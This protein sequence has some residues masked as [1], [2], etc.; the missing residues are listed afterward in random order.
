MVRNFL[1]RNF[2]LTLFLIISSTVLSAVNLTISSPTNSSTYDNGNSIAYRVKISNPDAVP[3][4]NLKLEVPLSTLTSTLDSGGSGA[5]FSNLL[6][7]VSPAGTTV[8]AVT[9]T[10]SASGDFL[11]TGITIPVGGSV[12]YT[13]IGTV[14]SGVNGTVNVVSTLKDSSNTILSTQNKSLTRVPYTYTLTKTSPSTYYEQNGTII[15]SVKATNTGS[16]PIYGMNITDTLPSGVTGTNIVGISSGALSDDGTFANTG[17]L[18]ASGVS[19]DAGGYVQYTIIASVNAG[20]TAPINNSATAT[21]RNTPTTSN[22]LNLPLAT[23]NFSIT[24]TNVNSNYIPGSTAS[25]KVRVTNNDSTVKITG[26]TVT[27][28]LSGITALSA[29]GTTKPVFDMTTATISAVTSGVGTNAGTFLATG[30][31]N[32]TGV[33][34]ATSGG[35]VEYTLTAKVQGDIVGPIINPASA[36]DRNGV[37]KS[38]NSTALNSAPPTLT[39]SKNQSPTTTFTPGSSIQYDVIVSNTGSGIAKD[40]NV[41]DLI[42]GITSNLANNGTGTNS[43]DNPTGQPMS[44]WSVSSFLSPAGGKTI[45]ALIS[46]G[47][48]SNNANINDTV[49][50]FPGESIHY[51]ITLNTKSTSIGNISN[52]A[53]LKDSASAPVANSGAKTYTAAALAPTSSATITKITNSTEYKPG[54]TVTYYITVT[55]PDPTKFMDNLAINDLINQIKST[56]LAGNQAQAFANWTV[57]VDSQTGAGTM[58]GDF[59]YGV[60]G[61]TNFQVVADIGPGGSITYKLVAKI[62]DD[63][64]GTILDTAIPG[65]NVIENGTG[66]KMSSPVLEVAK[67]VNTTEYTPGATLVYS[68]TVDNPG[69]GYAINIPVVDNFPSIMTTVLGGG[70]GQAY[71]GWQVVASVYDITNPSSPVLITSPTTTNPGFTGTASGGVNDSFNVTATL[72]PNR[73]IL[74]TMTVVINPLAIGKIVNEAKVNN[75]LVSDKGA[76]TRTS[77][78]TFAKSVDQESYPTLVGNKLTYT[79]VVSNNSVAGLAMGVDVT[80]SINSIQAE[81]LGSGAMANVFTSWTITAVPTGT[82][83]STQLTSP[84]SG[85]NLV[86]KVNIAPGGNITYTI[87]GTLAT[88]SGDIFY[89]PITNSAT[90]QGITDTATTYPKLP[91]LNLVKKTSSP[92]YTPGG[93]VTF[94]IDIENN[95]DGYANNASV[96]DSFPFDKLSGWT[97]TATKT[98]TGTTTGTFTD[99]QNLNT[100]VDIAPRGKVSYTVVA[101]VKPGTTGQI[102]NTASVTDIQNGITQTGSAIIS[103]GG[104]DGDGSVYIKK[105]T[106]SMTF[107]PDGTITYFIDVTNVSGQPVNNLSVKDLFGSNKSTYADNPN[108][109]TSDVADLLNHPTFDSWTI[110]KG[111]N[112]SNP[113]T[114]L[115]PLGTTDLNDTLGTLA[116]G[117]VVTYKV[118]AKVNIR[119]VSPKITNVAELYQNSVKI[120]DSQIEHKIIPPGG[121]ITRTVDKAFYVPGVD[122]ITY[123]ITATSTGP[124]FQN[125]LSLAENINNLSVNLIDGG[126]GNPF[127]NYVTNKNEF[128]VA[129]TI[130]DPSGNVRT[131]YTKGPADNKD[132]VGTLDIPPG[133]TIVYT[134]TGKVRPDAMGLIDNNGLLT[135]QHRYNLNITKKADLIKYEPG[136]PMVYT[137]DIKNNST[138]NAENIDVIDNFKNI[139]VTDS[140]GNQV[141]AFT[142]ITLLSQTV[143]SGYKATTNDTSVYPNPMVNGVLHTLADIPTP[144]EIQYKV[145]VQVTDKA[146]SAIDNIV[147]VGGDSVSNEVGPSTPNL[148]PTKKILN[149]YDLDGTTVLTN[150]YRPGGYVEYEIKVKNIGKGILDNAPFTDDIAGVQ[151]NYFDGTTGKAFDSW[152]IT[153]AGKDTIGTNVTKPDIDGQIQNSTSINTHVDIAAGGYFTYVVKA[154]INEKAVGTFKNSFTVGGITRESENSNMAP[155]NIVFTKKAFEA[156]GTTV[157][158]TFSPGD[159]VVYKVRIDNTGNGTD[160]LK[161]LTDIVSG[162]TATIAEDGLNGTNPTAPVFASYQITATTSGGNVTN[163]GTFT[164]PQTGGDVNQTIS[165]ASKG[166]VELVITGVLKN[167]IIGAFTNRAIYDGTTKA[168]TLNPKAPTLTLSKTLT[169]LAGAPFV[170]GTTK[171]KPGDS[172]K[173]IVDIKNTG[174]TFFDN[175]VITDT[176]NNVVT[177]LTGGSTGPALTNVAVSVQK[178]PSGG[179]TY[180]P[181]PIGTTGVTINQEID[182]APG[183]ELIY[184]ITGNISNDALGTISANSVRA[185]D[186]GNVDVTKT[187]DV[188]L[189]KSPVI[190]TAKTLTSLLPDRIYTPGGTV[191]YRLTMTNSGDGYGN[192]IPMK[193]ILTAVQAEIVGGGTAQAF[194]AWTITPTITYSLPQY[195]GNETNYTGTLA[196]NNDLNIT[197]DIAPG[198]TITVDIVATIRND[199]VGD[200]KNIAVLNGTNKD[201][202]VISSKPG[203]INVT[204]GTTTSSYA[205]DGPL[206]FVVVLTNSSTNGIANN[207]SLTDI[208]SNIQVT[209]AG[210]TLKPAFKP[211]WTISTNIFG[212]NSTTYTAGIPVSGDINTSNIDIGPS[213][214]VV[215]NIN[216]YA[217]SDAVG[218]IVNIGKWTYK[219]KVDQ[220]LTAT[221]IPGPGKLEISKIASSDTYSPGSTITYTMDIKNTGTGYLNNVSILDDILGIQAQIAGAPL[222]TGQAFSSFNVVSV[223]T[224]SSNT[225]VLRDNAYTTGYKAIADIYPGEKVSVKISAVVNANVLGTITNS[226]IADEVGKDP[227]HTD[228]TISPLPPSLNI[229][230]TV[231]KAVYVYQDTLTYNLT[232]TN[233]GVGWA[234]DVNVTD[235]I[236]GIQVSFIDGT[237]GPAFEPSWTISA[238]TTGT[239]TT[240]GVYSN[241]TNINTTVDIAPGGSVTYKIVAQIK[242][243]AN[244]EILNFGNYKLGD[245]LVKSNEVISNPKIAN[246]SITKTTK[247]GQT[248]YAVDGKVNYLITVKNLENTVANNVVVKDLISSIIVRSSAGTPLSPPDFIN[249]FTSWKI[250][251]VTHDSGDT[252]LT[253]VI[254]TIGISSSTQDIEVD[255]SLSSL[256]TLTIEVEATVNPGLASLPDGS[257]IGNIINIASV[258]YNGT[259]NTSY[260]TV[261]PLPPILNTTKKI[262][263]LGSTVNPTDLT[264][265]P[266][267]DIE[268]TIRVTNSGQGIADNVIIEDKISEITT[269]LSGGITGQPALETGW[270]I[271]FVEFDTRTQIWPSSFAPGSDILMN[272]DISPNGYLEIK[273][274]G[275]IVKNAIGDISGNSVKVNDTE[276]KTPILTPSPGALSSSKVIIDGGSEV[277][278]NT[279][280]QGGTL[281]YKI[282]VNNT[283]LGFARNVTLVDTISGIMSEKVGGGTTNAFNSWTVSATYNSSLGTTL[284]GT[285]PAT[286]MDINEDMDIAPGD[287][288]V[289][290]VT[291]TLV[292]NVVGNI[293]NNANVKSTDLSYDKTHTVT[294]TPKTATVNVTKTAVNPTYVPGGAIGFDI[295]IENTSSDAIV[296]DFI[297][298]DSIS[299]ILVSKTGGGTD[300]AFAPGWT[301]TPVVIGDSLNSDVSLVPTSGDISNVKIDIGKSTEV[302]IQIRGTATNDIY[303]PIVNNG[304]WSYGPDTNKPITATIDSIDGKISIIKDVDSATYVPGGDLT[305]TVKIKN[306]STGIAAGVKI[307]DDIL[308]IQAQIAGA[309]TP[310]GNAFASIVST[311][312]TAGST[313]TIIT[314]NAPM[315]AN[316]YYATADIAPGDT[317]TVVIKATLNENV[318]GEVVNTAKAKYKDSEVTDDASSVSEAGKLGIYKTEDK[319]KYIPNQDMNYKVY[320]TNTGT[321]WIKNAVVRDDITS[322]VAQV[323]GNTTGPVFDP[324]S[325]VIT[326]SSVEPTNSITMNPAANPNL[327]ANVDIKPGTTIIFDIK[328]TVNSNVVGNIV[329]LATVTDENGKPTQSNEVIAVQDIPDIQFSKTAN[330][331][332]YDV[333]GQVTYTVTLRN[334]TENSIDNIYLMDDI[335]GIRATDS[336]GNSVYPFVETSLTGLIN[337]VKDP[338]VTINSSGNPAQLA[339]IG[340]PGNSQ[341]TFTITLTIKDNIVGNILN[342]A[343]K[344][345]DEKSETRDVTI[346]PKKPVINVTKTV[347]TSNGGDAIFEDGETVTYTVTINETAGVPAFNVKVTDAIRALVNN[348]TPAVPVFDPATIRVLGV[349]GANGTTPIPYTGTISGSSDV[350]TIN[351]VITKATVVIEAVVNSNVGFEPG[352]KLNNT[353]YVEVRQNPN[354][355]TPDAT[356]DGSVIITPINPVLSV[357]KAIKTASGRDKLYPNE[358]V[359]YTLTLINSSAIDA[360]DENINLGKPGVSLKDNIAAITDLHGDQ[361]YTNI[362]IV[363][364]QSSTG[365]T[366]PQNNSP[367]DNTVLSYSGDIS[368]TASEIIFTRVPKNSSM[369]VQIE[370]TVKSDVVFTS[371]E[372]IRNI[373]ELGDPIPSNPVDIVVGQNELE[374]TK[375]ANVDEILLGEPVTYT[376]T[377]KNVGQGIANNVYVIDKIS[378]ITGTSFSGKTIPAF[379]DWTI[380][381]TATDG[382]NA[383]TYTSENA[384]L[385]V[386]DALIQPGGTITYTIV[387]HTSVDLDEKSITNV[388]IVTD[389]PN[390]NPKESSVKTTIKKPMITINKTVGVNEAS[391]G[392][393][394]PY[395]IS[396]KNNEKE[397]VKNVYIR[398]II[399]AGLKYVDGSTILIRSSGNKEV[400]EVQG[401]KEL[402]MGPFDLASNEM[403]EISYLL[404]VSVGAVKGR[405]KNLAMA[406]NRAGSVLSNESSAEVDIVEDP[407]FEK[408]TVLGKVFHDRDGDGY[409]DSFVASKIK[410][411]QNILESNYVPESTVLDINGRKVNVPDASVPLE[412]GIKVAGDLKGRLSEDEPMD[413]NKIDIYTG[414]TSVENLGD[415]RVTTAEGT[416]ITLKS[417]GTV[418]T[419]HKGMKRAGMTA[420]NIVVQRKILRAKGSGKEL[421]GVPYYQVITIMNTGIQ[422]EGL[423]GVRLATVEG[424]II[425][426]DQY[427]RYHIPE[428]SSSKG[429][430]FIIKVDPT[431]LPSGTTFTTENPKVQTLGSTPIKFNFGVIIPEIK[432]S[433]KGESL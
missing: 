401:T 311:N 363:S 12:E 64:I 183:D 237:T 408:S 30:D 129:V 206:N 111:L 241:G 307:S 77:S 266:G 4:T 264:Y 112:N 148:T 2:L 130:T 47:G 382:S 421:S 219:D 295:V 230:K 275:K 153:L 397:P 170:A 372:V 277:S 3:V 113:S 17:N 175:L 41:S 254:P 119:V 20:Q 65:D 201:D 51:V 154:K 131:L 306:E 379:T 392:K 62:N 88:P 141:P 308:G 425:E 217:I 105:R 7:A 238:T 197:V 228:K 99:G 160:Y 8:G 34:I 31:L 411:Q 115:T 249:A 386:K 433:E 285:Y 110:Y 52:T 182:F 104:T 273:I 158:T 23:Y 192:N 239:G 102:E 246:L 57:T 350:I 368:D 190:T 124:G 276:V 71:N 245:T 319:T 289:F 416:D 314:P 364:V 385:I 292:N 76:I 426:T 167:T 355:E 232:V 267:E 13:I 32:A 226:L 68:F 251:S 293:V 337:V 369:I 352:E 320:V 221:I 156:N 134:I 44:S 257:P 318:V 74:Y 120:G 316:G 194:T 262:T 244:G 347:S 269:E 59:A 187:S 396:V 191:S 37:V 168:V 402:L 304:L 29:N 138:G 213:T 222:A 348:T 370:A 140:E 204:K 407:L 116:S 145:Q 358:V 383:G 121:G 418:V 127:Y 172:V 216:G 203:V 24:K 184:T 35:Y 280:T 186:S 48:I 123:T 161:N 362:H 253:T 424:L 146:V 79:L 309:G 205:P 359:T 198:S 152:T 218:D 423:P 106:D 21:V 171:Y 235:N 97:I 342:T 163:L 75:V 345:Y 211:G 250:V 80:D 26:M 390:L 388:A 135:D 202:G 330:I 164:S 394:V 341:V 109:G 6:N 296:N 290:T 128:T 14:N 378:E 274:K 431:T 317:V 265:T 137:I 236:S 361:V 303:G 42:T 335:L 286:S 248:S 288:V 429:K 118:V 142:S 399:P 356:G 321:G 46:A 282:V 72:G 150:G 188:I 53:F 336:N 200:I 300:V 176:V 284:S 420:Q 405:Y 90:A 86:D 413:R 155:K 419:D 371:G 16:A 299:T 432:Y 328:A 122:T 255:T 344:V 400:I 223:T 101:T 409:Q 297:L 240:S 93:T 89:G 84:V 270:T 283:G 327:E 73:R 67:N 39:I 165:I 310:L 406:V 357:T 15:Y 338:G 149:Y 227:I 343:I 114:V 179:I 18:N 428:V 189:P 210:G 43:V 366:I 126:T 133:S 199:A 185:K 36:T 40:Y 70:T 415:I 82:G 229:S 412:R 381:S 334:N 55:N 395:L 312:A 224:T 85:V 324:T 259:K 322:I 136:K 180:L 157:K 91:L 291:G 193:D 169:E 374:I 287:S 117:D 212:S 326:S 260:V 271:S 28:L 96:I 208:I 261:D 422:E 19:I 329:N 10:F 22:S 365:A 305:Y 108:G 143:I 81:L 27:D 375:K 258:T 340:M 231:D 252:P 404:K 315:P 174:T 173:Y 107:A 144:G 256:E 272:A 351:E 94:T 50:I 151:T 380:T 339:T 313:V 242:A 302:I 162:I 430:N 166:Y 125:N 294:S 331:T 281:V 92:T 195:S 5:V 49:T 247:D 159:T 234:N 389:E 387:A 61:T 63:I 58:P 279:Y 78:V 25:F 354:S 243:D 139:M 83:S 414:L 196:N 45:S 325:I 103:D 301:I 403:I 69:D 38:I 177:E 298:N 215:I 9:G 220:P 225:T 417:D 373:A 233:T 147:L 346:T 33:T 178:I 132:L 427:G 393:F 209:T 54:D 214:S 376:I 349:Y 367:T 398:D 56:N 323:L 181:T 377:V 353:A 332:Q 60:N 66:I 95:G 410:V 278:T 333:N 268:Y 263:L 87:V 100:T 360:I 1:R 98:G 384:D 391:V 11:A 207:V